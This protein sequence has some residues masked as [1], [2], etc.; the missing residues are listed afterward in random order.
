MLCKCVCVCDRES[1]RVSE[2][3]TQRQPFRATACTC[4]LSG[5][6]NPSLQWQIVPTPLQPWWITAASFTF[7]DALTD[8]SRHQGPVRWADI[9]RRARAR[10]HMLFFIHMEQL[11]MCNSF[12][13]CNRPE[14]RGCQEKWHFLFAC[15]FYAI[16][17]PC[18][19]HI[20]CMAN[21]CC[22]SLNGNWANVTF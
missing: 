21:Q 11:H 5:M 9:R 16:L 8:I 10:T 6:L 12:H 14:S 15:I 2:C 22:M 1:E 19:L 18:C 3:E 7:A 20:S 4:L 17:I 13:P